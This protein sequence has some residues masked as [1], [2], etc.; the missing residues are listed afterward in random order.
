MVLAWG[1]KRLNIA[2]TS[3][4]H[5]LKIQSA[6]TLGPKEKIVVVT[7]EGRKL[8][9]G[10]TS[11][12]ITML[13]E[14]ECDEEFA[15]NIPLKDSEGATFSQQIRKILNQGNVNEDSTAS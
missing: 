10:V 3:F 5:S 13:S 9:L 7:V 8:L 14:L 1:A 15:N 11:Q 2:N 4:N 6:L 12:N